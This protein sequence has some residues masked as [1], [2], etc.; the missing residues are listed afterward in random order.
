MVPEPVSLFTT[1]A[2]ILNLVRGTYR[3][4][5]A[6]TVEWKNY[7]AWA[8][9]R[10]KELRTLTDDVERWQRRWMVWTD[11]EGLYDL[12]W[13]PESS[14]IRNDLTKLKAE[15]GRFTKR[16]NK[17]D[18]RGKSKVRVMGRK[19]K[20]T[21]AIHRGPQLDT[22][23][24][25]IQRRFKNLEND[26][27]NA[28]LKVPNRT[29]PLDPA[30]TVLPASRIRL[31]GFARILVRLALATSDTS[32]QLHYRALQDYGEVAMELDL[33]MFGLDIKC[34]DRL[35]RPMASPS[36]AGLEHT[37]DRSHA[38]AISAA[39]S[40]IHY[41]FMVKHNIRR[42]MWSR[43]RTTA[44]PIINESN[45][46][47]RYLTFGEAVIFITDGDPAHNHCGVDLSNNQASVVVRSEIGN[48][49]G[50]IPDSEPL[51]RVLN[52][53]PQQQNRAF[54]QIRAKQALQVAEFGLLFFGT[55]WIR[56]ICSCN[57]RQLNVMTTDGHAAS[58]DQY[59]LTLR[60][61]TPSSPYIPTDAVPANHDS[62]RHACWCVEKGTDSQSR[63]SL[64]QDLP[65]FHLGLV[66]IEVV[67]STPLLRVEI[68]E[69]PVEAKNLRLTYKSSGNQATSTL[70]DMRETLDGYGEDVYDAIKF[71][72]EIPWS[73]G[74]AR[75]DDHWKRNLDDYYW[76]V[77]SP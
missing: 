47:R 29:D 32:D 62:H 24:E 43:I 48:I 51:R 30:S 1:V 39:D 53:V 42:Q 20:D 74:H 2:G 75:N 27:D 36:I 63:M 64:A 55:T 35:P 10:R 17:S 22:A 14:E 66:L 46:L 8:E 70:E 5:Q 56:S 44:D 25:K 65:L 77:V 4:L 49:Q 16:L 31:V 76:T 73:P 71:C 68:N 41:T 28:F 6:D 69:A 72:V 33:D 26:S 57:I 40:A 60:R 23:L 61:L 67:L 38:M 50:H 12:F 45:S 21:L 9:T 19:A 58:D 54:A 13:G 11:D 7:E 34:S 52:T 15:I 59:R 3:S 18:P 37:V